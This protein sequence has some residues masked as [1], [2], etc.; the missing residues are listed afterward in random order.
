MSWS[1]DTVA[2]VLSG[3]GSTVGATREAVETAPTDPN[4][5]SVWYYFSGIS[6]RVSLL[7]TSTDFKFDTAVAVYRIPGDSLSTAVLVRLMLVRLM[8]ESLV[9]SVK[10][11]GA[12]CV[13]RRLLWCPLRKLRPLGCCIVRDLRRAGTTAVEQCLQY[14]R[15]LP[16]LAR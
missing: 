15:D 1:C 8:S 14:P 6:G 7:V 16:P 13:Q 12:G 9:L 10:L 3:A 11:V 2:T 4:P 5:K